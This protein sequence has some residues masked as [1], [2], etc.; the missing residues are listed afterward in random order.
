MDMSSLLKKALCQRIAAFM[1]VC[2]ALV[3]C[4]ASTA[5]AATEAG[6]GCPQETG[7]VVCVDQNHQLLWVQQGSQ[8]VFP[9]VTVRTGRAGHR[10]PDGTYHIYLRN[11]TQWSHLFNQPMP[12]SQFFHR[13]FALHGVYQDVRK[14]GSTGCVNL[15]SDDAKRLWDILGKGDL[16]YVWGHKRK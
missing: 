6:Q 2:S 4:T 9:A 11:K 1:T 16:V 3:A 13:G 8:T 5:A 10:T 12:Y 14:G 15:T 7:R